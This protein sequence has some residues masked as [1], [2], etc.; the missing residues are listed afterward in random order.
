[1][2]VRRERGDGGEGGSHLC[3]PQPPKPVG[4][5]VFTA[6]GFGGGGGG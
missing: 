5:F 2:S 4:C 1:M 3:G 6:A